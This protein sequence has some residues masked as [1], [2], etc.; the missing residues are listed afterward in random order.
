MKEEECEASA[1][2]SILVWPSMLG[3]F[4]GLGKIRIYH[5]AGIVF[6]PQ[7]RVKSFSLPPNLRNIDFD[8]ESDGTEFATAVIAHNL[9]FPDLQSLKLTSS[10]QVAMPFIGDCKNLV[11][12]SFRVNTLKLELLPPFLT[13][14]YAFAANISF[15][16]ASS[17]PRSLKSLRLSLDTFEPFID[18]LPAEL[19]Q[20]EFQGLFQGWP[21]TDSKNLPR[22]LTRLDLETWQH[23]FEDELSNLPPRLTRPYLDIKIDPYQGQLLPRTLTDTNALPWIYVDE[24]TVFPPNLVD[25]NGSVAAAPTCRGL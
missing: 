14:L 16:C 21:L 23:T 4:L 6:G 7:W 9:A 10:A 5:T 17:F 18:L 25:M 19:E 11:S 15:N 24:Q 20:F 13:E 1:F 8:F 3:N 12:L 2:F 22:G